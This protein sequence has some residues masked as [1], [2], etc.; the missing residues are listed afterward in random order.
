L[1]AYV[2][3]TA[4]DE[5]V[6]RLVDQHRHSRL[7]QAD[8]DAQRPS[9]AGGTTARQQAG[10][11]ADRAVQA[12]HDVGDG[13]A[14]LGRLRRA[15]DRHQPA[16]R[17]RHDVVAG[18]VGVGTVAAGTADRHPD[19][20]RRR[21]QRLEPERAQ[22]P[23][24]E[25]LDHDVGRLDELRHDGP[26]LRPR[27]VERDRAPVAVDGEEVGRVVA[28]EGRPPVAG[29][30]AETG[31]LD[32]QDVGAEVGQHHAAVGA[33]EHPGQVQD[34]HAAERSG[35]GLLDRPARS[36]AQRGH[37]VVHRPDPA[38]RAPRGPTVRAAADR[39]RVAHLT[40]SAQRQVHV[41]GNREGGPA[42]P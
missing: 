36:G 1:P 4:P 14:H 6:G 39:S 33:G 31:P 5:R 7:E 30:V 25:V 21:P 41:P 26:P 38:T 12:R 34:A 32:L 2:G 10:E 35:G 27:E 3:T 17:L 11:R 19:R 13:H 9:G 28:V 15:G 20:L 23:R 37:E 8:L 22:V 18:L 24:Q 42:T 40:T 29:V 16:A